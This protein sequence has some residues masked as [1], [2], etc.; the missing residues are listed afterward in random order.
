MNIL[1]T[2]GTGYLGFS[3]V[4]QLLD[5]DNVDKVVVYDNASSE[6]AFFVGQ[7]FLNQYKLFYKQGDILDNYK[8]KDILKKHEITTVIHLAAKA[9]TP[10]A[11]YDAHSFDQV[12]NWGTACVVRAIEDSDTVEKIIYLSSISVY[13]N[14]K[15]SFVS[16][17]TIPNP[18]TIYAVSK[19]RG[20]KHVLRLEGKRKICVIRAGNIFGYNHAIR[21][22]SVF[23]KLVF[24]ANFHNRIEIHGSGN[25]FRA[26]V[27]VDELAKSILDFIFLENS[28]KV[29][30]LFNGNLS[31]NQISE[32]IRKVF[33]NVETLFIDQ[34]IDM[35]SVKAESKYTYNKTYTDENF[36][37]AI[38]S[39]KKRFTFINSN[40]V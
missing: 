13:G 24:D 32:I 9:A 6:S 39:I 16:E 4:M 2:G 17:N 10:F 38:L 14:Q 12:N 31:I 36:L 34:H 8:L 22:Q 25:Q 18:K 7:N 5:N 37:N 20:E 29:I 19:F 23:N 3:L 40:Y 30:N 33:P 1:I 27:N 28:P 21:F 11:D 35:R 26:F 15:G